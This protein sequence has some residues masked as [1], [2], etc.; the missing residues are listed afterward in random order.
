MRIGMAGGDREDVQTDRGV[1]G[2]RGGSSSHSHVG[3]VVVV[4]I[5]IAMGP[6]VDTLM[7]RESIVELVV[8]YGSC[9]H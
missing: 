8:V 5:A 2:E 7:G 6:H 3:S 9:I 1:N 4:A